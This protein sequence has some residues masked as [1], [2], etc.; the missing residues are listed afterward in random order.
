VAK[1]DRL[2]TRIFS[3]VIVLLFVIPIVFGAVYVVLQANDGNTASNTATVN[4]NTTNQETPTM[5]ENKLEGKPLANF[6]PST[7]KVTALQVTDTVVG[8][9]DTVQP[10]AT[11]TMDY[12]GA[13]V[14]NGVV[15]QSSLD[16]GQPITYPLTDLIKGWQEGVP[17]MKVG[18]TRRLVIPSDQA[19]GA[20]AQGGIPANSDLVFDITLRAIK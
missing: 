20:N 8:T 6:T 17:G 3:I 19:Y 15:F 11:V 16:A 1:V 18:G 12:T 4:T 7:E 10:G 9:G 2:P 13:L 5:N 14:A